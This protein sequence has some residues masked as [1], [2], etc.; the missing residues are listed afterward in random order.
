MGH[1]WDIQVDDILL[2][3][4][5]ENLKPGQELRCAERVKMKKGPKDGSWVN[6]AQVERKNA[7][8]RKSI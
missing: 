3:V 2:H 6:L 1:R 7:N 4:G 5:N 8:E